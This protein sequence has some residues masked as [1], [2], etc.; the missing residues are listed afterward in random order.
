[1]PFP[2]PSIATPD[3]TT[4]T[5][6]QMGTAMREHITRLRMS[7][8]SGTL[9]G[10]AFAATG[11]TPEQPAVITHSRG[12]ERLRET[13]TW[14]T[15][16]GAAGN[17]ESILYEYSEDSGSNWL[18]VGTITYTYDASGNVTAAAWS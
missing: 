12:V 7:L 9:A 10:F 16:A 6:A 13:V 15:A 17:P 2:D 14:G 18:T 4:Q 5:L 8:A 11:G 3:A 1:M